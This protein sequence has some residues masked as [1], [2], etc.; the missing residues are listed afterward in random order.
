[1]LALGL[2]EMDRM[3]NDKIAHLACEQEVDTNLRFASFLAF[4][5]PLREDT[6]QALKVLAVPSPRV[7]K[8]P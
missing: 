4:H 8:L 5:F 7:R 3:S 6:V 1:M 2:K